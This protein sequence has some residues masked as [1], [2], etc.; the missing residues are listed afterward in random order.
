[1][2]G[3][4]VW[5]YLQWLITGTIKEDVSAACGVYLPFVFHWGWTIKINLSAVF[6]GLVVVLLFWDFFFLLLVVSTKG[7]RLKYL[8][9]KNKK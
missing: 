1:M 2:R 9:S 4:V 7:R 8:C 3:V 6:V 5:C